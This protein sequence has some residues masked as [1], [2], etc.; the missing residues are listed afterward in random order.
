MKIDFDQIREL[1]A[2]VSQTDITEL[3]VESGDQRI[4]VKKDPPRSA[5]STVRIPAES[6]IQAPYPEVKTEV[7]EEET[8]DRS[9]TERNGLVPIASP[10]VGTFYRAPS[11]SAPPFVEIGD[12]VNIGQTV[13]IIEAMKL[14]ND[15]PAEVSGR[16]VEV[17]VESGTTV[18]YGQPLFMVDPSG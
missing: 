1:L 5:T 11:P 16:V 13:C 15:M 18:E 2:V 8:V 9:H 6:H 14:M 3:T 17:C 12:T 4:T 7:T 10:M